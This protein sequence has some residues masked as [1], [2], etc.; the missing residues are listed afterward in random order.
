M[1]NTS[2]SSLTGCHKGSL[3]GGVISLLPLVSHEVRQNLATIPASPF[4]LSCF[5]HSLFP[6]PSPSI[7]SKTPRPPHQVLPQ[8]P[9]AKTEC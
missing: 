1:K 2:W 7:K 9:Q 4:A 8:R 3:Q 6:E 5:P